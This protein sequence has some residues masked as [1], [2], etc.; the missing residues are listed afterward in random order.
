MQVTLGQAQS[1]QGTRSPRRSHGDR[2][3][4]EDVPAHNHMHVRMWFEGQVALEDE[5]TRPDGDAFDS[6]GLWDEQAAEALARHTLEARKDVMEGSSADTHA[7]A[8]GNWDLDPAS[9]SPV[10]VHARHRLP[11][12]DM[13]ADI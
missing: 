13:S 2:K 4:R 3:A 5:G 11:V 12:A 8:V 7:E 1:D 10:A 9:A 6:L